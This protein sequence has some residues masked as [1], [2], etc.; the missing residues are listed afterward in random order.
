MGG[1]ITSTILTLI[2]V[3]VVYS[4]LDDFAQ[5]VHRRM[6]GS[7]FEAH[8]AAKSAAAMLL[9]MTLSGLVAIPA[10]AQETVSAKTVTLEQALRT[11]ADHNRDIKKAEEYGKWVRG[12]YVEARAGA[13]PRFTLT[14]GGLRQYDASQQDYLKDLPAE[15]KQFFSFQQDI[16]TWDLGME[17]A[18]FT[19]GKVGA[20]IRGAKFGLATA[21]DQLRLWRQAVRRDVT[22]AFYNVLLAKEL[23]G[24]AQRNVQQKQRHLDEATRRYEAGVAT[25]YDVLAARVALD[26][27][28]PE[29]IAAATNVR[30]AREQL[31][32]LLAEVELEVDAQGSLVPEPL[33]APAYPELVARAVERR[34]EIVELGHRREVARGLAKIAGASDKPRLDLRG[35]YGGRWIDNGFAKSNGGIWNLGVYLRFSVFD[36]LE[37]RGKVAQAR[38]GSRPQTC[39]SN[40]SS[41][42]WRCRYA[43]PSTP[44]RS[45]RRP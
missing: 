39:S 34:P 16:R 11:A 23:D 14:A 4:L 12:K 13:F 28:R 17:Q 10:A 29:A 36:G 6:A 35:G 24:I 32:F 44:W 15:F 40:S 1:L 37:T 22:A 31:G 26:N 20:A 2:I 25:D 30:T 38:G 33:A 5:W 43:R 27:A 18:L 19:W 42:P 8:E 45:P 3:P 21:E 9:V 41:S 7:Q